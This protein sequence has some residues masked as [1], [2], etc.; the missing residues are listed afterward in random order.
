MM[1]KKEYLNLNEWQIYW[2]WY[3]RENY[4]ELKILI[5]KLLFFF[6]G[7]EKEKEK[8]IKMKHFQTINF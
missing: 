6:S 7:I 5:N 2:K 8:H 1:E 3:E 4:D